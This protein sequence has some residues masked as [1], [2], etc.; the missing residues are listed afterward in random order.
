MNEIGFSSQSTFDPFQILILLLFMVLIG[1]VGYLIQRK[2]GAFNT[3]LSTPKNA[4][5]CDWKTQ[6]LVKEDLVYS[7]ED[8]R[9]AYLVLKTSSGVLLLNKEA[10]NKPR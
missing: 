2:M 8:D 3:W 9:H 10:K 1:G 4:Q 6:G 5:I 7:I